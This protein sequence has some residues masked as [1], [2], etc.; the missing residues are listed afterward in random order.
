MNENHVKTDDKTIE[1]KNT[2]FDIIDIQKVYFLQN[3]NSCLSLAS[4]PMFCCFVDHV[5]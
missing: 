5:L 1:I 4:G 3:S 2:R